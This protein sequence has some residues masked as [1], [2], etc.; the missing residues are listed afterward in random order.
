MQFTVF[1]AALAV[2]SGVFA[3]PASE[4]VLAQQS[5]Q[6]HQA[7]QAGQAGQAGQARQWGPLFGGLGYGYGGWGYGYPGYYGYGW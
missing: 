1:V 4:N 5:G 3:N 2:C 7:T 6:A